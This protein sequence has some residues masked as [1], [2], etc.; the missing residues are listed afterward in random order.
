MYGGSLEAAHIGGFLQN[1]TQSYEPRI[2]EF[3]VKVMGINSV[4]DIG[5]GRGISTKWFMDHGARVQCA[6]ATDEGIATTV[7][8]SKNLITQHDYTQG[9]WWPMETFDAVS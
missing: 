5:C 7:L 6:E 2:W 3:M 8:P 1:D 9:P 4:M